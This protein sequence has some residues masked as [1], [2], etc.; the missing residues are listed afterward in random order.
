MMPVMGNGGPFRETGGKEI[1]TKEDY[2]ETQVDD[3]CKSLDRPGHG[4]DAS[5]VSS[6]AGSGQPLP[7]ADESSKS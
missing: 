2:Y 6:G 4:M 1:Y 5:R 3:S 7:A